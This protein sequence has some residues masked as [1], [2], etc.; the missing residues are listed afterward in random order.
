MNKRV[1][2]ELIASWGDGGLEKHYI[3]LCNGIAD[4]GHRVIAIHP[5][6]VQIPLVAGVEK[7]P[8]DMSGWRYSP[9]TAMRLLRLIRAVQP[10]AV[11]AQAGRAATLLSL[12]KPWLKQPTLA[13]VHNQKKTTRPY[14]SANQ[15][16]AV[17]KRALDFLPRNANAVA[18]YN[19]VETPAP[20]STINLLDLFSTK[21]PTILLHCCRYIAIADSGALKP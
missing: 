8:L 1:I 15:I 2:V 17:S 18:I 10:D 3:D 4:R 20:N 12:I 11:H 21:R 7:R 5:H 19:G 16:I 14:L 6:D 9:V 13:T